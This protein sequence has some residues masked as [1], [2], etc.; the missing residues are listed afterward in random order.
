M[1]ISSVVINHKNL[2]LSDNSLKFLQDFSMDLNNSSRLKENF[3]YLIKKCISFSTSSACK[4]QII[5]SA[6]N[7]Y[8]ALAQSL[9]DEHLF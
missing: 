9:T 2:F 4:L 6:L 1:K 8:I 3:C 7:F 5:L